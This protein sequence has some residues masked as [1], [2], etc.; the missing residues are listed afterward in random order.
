MLHRKRLLKGGHVDRTWETLSHPVGGE[1]G[2][3]GSDL[4]ISACSYLW[5]TVIYAVFNFNLIFFPNTPYTQHISLNQASGSLSVIWNVTV[6][7]FS[8][9]RTM[10]H[11]CI[12]IRLPG[13]WHLHAAFS[14]VSIKSCICSAQQEPCFSE[15]M[16]LVDRLANRT[17]SPCR[18]ERRDKHR[19]LWAAV[20]TN[21]VT[22]V[23]VTKQHTPQC[24]VPLGDLSSLGVHTVNPAPYLLPWLTSSSPEMNTVIEQELCKKTHSE[25]W[26]TEEKQAWNR[27]AVLSRVCSESFGPT[28]VQQ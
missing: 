27:L 1:G 18:Q 24:P 12:Y 22:S 23:V 21:P 25:R 8:V 26:R 11:I 6:L 10:C 4:Q 28:M 14:C 2:T 7:F 16:R 3:T 5:L 19:L 13:K 9:S 17:S 15:Q 20:E